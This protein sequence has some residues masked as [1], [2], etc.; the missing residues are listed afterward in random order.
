M[1]SSVKEIA[2][3]KSPGIGYSLCLINYY[4]Q[5]ATFLYKEDYA[6]KY[7]DKQWTFSHVI[8]GRNKITLFMWRN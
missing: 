5:C 2:A 1:K 3:F 4:N 6:Y 8:R 7:E